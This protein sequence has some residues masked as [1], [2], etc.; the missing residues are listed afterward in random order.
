M[1][2]NKEVAVKIHELPAKPLQETI[3]DELSQKKNFKS[4]KNLIK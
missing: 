4:H 2:E 1:N 3:E